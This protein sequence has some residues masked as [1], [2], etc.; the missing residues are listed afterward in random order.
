MREDMAK[1]IVTRPRVGGSWSKARR[2]PAPDEQPHRESMRARWKSRKHLNE[3]LSPLRRFLRKQ[4]GR[5]WDAVYSEICANLSVTS[6][7]QQHVRDHLDDYVGRDAFVRDGE[8]YVMSGRWDTVR[9]LSSSRV[10][11]FVCPRT[12]LLRANPFWRQ[13]P[14]AQQRREAAKA[15]QVMRAERMKEISEFVQLHRLKGQ[16]FEVRL[17][18]VRSESSRPYDD[19]LELCGYLAAFALSETKL[20]DVVLATGAWSGSRAALYGRSGVRGV[21]KRQLSKKEL[22]RYGLRPTR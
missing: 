20:D 17:K 4:I 2:D 1:V 9:K 21:A 6:T 12:G 10:E 22:K 16:W 19:A 5:P 14:Y 8:L 13:R 18:P 3:T 15:G 11:L 7:V